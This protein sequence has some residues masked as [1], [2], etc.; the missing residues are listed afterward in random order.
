MYQT[1]FANRLSDRAPDLRLQPIANSIASPKPKIPRKRSIL[2]SF[3]PHDGT[4]GRYIET[5]IANRP[6]R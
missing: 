5:P 6:D 2:V 3:R 1:A 4:E